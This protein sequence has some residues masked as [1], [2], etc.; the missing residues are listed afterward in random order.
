MR[1]SGCLACEGQWTPVDEGEVTRSACM[2]PQS[3]KTTAGDERGE[4]LF[5][6]MDYTICRVNV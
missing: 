5:G 4:S 3:E 2:G 6:H 1:R